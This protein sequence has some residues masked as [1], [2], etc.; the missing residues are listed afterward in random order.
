METDFI[1]S[2][3]LGNYKISVN[4]RDTSEEIH[5]YAE[6]WAFYT[7]AINTIDA[8]RQ[9]N[10]SLIF[11]KKIHVKYPH[12][13]PILSDNIESSFAHPY[14]YVIYIVDNQFD[15]ATMIHELMPMNIVVMKKA[16][17]LG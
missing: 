2:T 13:N 4:T 8:L 7:L 14:N 17:L 15:E 5:R 16:W 1:K 12:N 11:T 10:P 6:M 9:Y 3:K